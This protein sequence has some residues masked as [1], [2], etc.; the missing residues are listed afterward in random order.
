MEMTDVEVEHGSLL[1]VVRGLQVCIF[2]DETL[3]TLC[4]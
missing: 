3:G 1:K 4:Q 2:F